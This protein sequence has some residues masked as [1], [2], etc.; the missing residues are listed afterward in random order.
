[1][2]FLLGAFGKLQA[3]ARYRDLQAKMMRVQSKLRRASRQ[4]ANFEKMLDRQQKT[5][6]QSINYG[7]MALNNAAQAS[8][9]KTEMGDFANANLG[10]LSKEDQAKYNN[11]YA[12]FNQALAQAKT[13]NEMNATMQKEW[14]ENYFQQ[15]RDTQLE[16]YKNEEDSLHL[17]KESLE[18]QI[19]V[20]KMDYD[21]CKEMEKS[22][23]PMLKPT[24]TA[25][26]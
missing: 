23:A 6:L 11:Y 12:A 13:T 4:V 18:S 7:T 14:I 20:A 9:W 17:E 16:A 3:G 1:M 10:D 19:Q 25:Q 15:L 8:L 26:A 21:A 22:D 5:M 2:G 24:Y